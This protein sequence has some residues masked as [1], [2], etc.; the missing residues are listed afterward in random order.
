MF[1]LQPLPVQHALTSLLQLALENSA[2]ALKMK[3]VELGTDRMPENILA[4]TIVNILES[5]PMLDVSLKDLKN[6]CSWNVCAYV[7]TA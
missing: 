6:V 1:V 4:P 7:I 3:V 2:G 5:E